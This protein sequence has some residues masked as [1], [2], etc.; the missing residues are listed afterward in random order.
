MSDFENQEN[1][2]PLLDYV[3]RF[4]TSNICV[5][6]TLCLQRHV[7]GVYMLATNAEN[8]N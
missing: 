6:L 3:C 4:I 8:E 7:Y 2:F 5:V 1:R